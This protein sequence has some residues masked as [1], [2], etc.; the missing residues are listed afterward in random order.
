M[1]SK[2]MSVIS[3]QFQRLVLSEFRWVDF[4]AVDITMSRAY[5]ATSISAEPQ[6]AKFA[7]DISSNAFG[8]IYRNLLPLLIGIG[9]EWAN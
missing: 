1:S 2:A 3:E 7:E 6:M 8:A 9:L 5:S 4:A